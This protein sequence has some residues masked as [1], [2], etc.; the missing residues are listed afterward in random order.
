MRRLMLNSVMN[1]LVLCC[2]GFL[3]VLIVHLSVGTTSVSFRR[4]A[5]PVELPSNSQI[6]EREDIKDLQLTV[7]QLKNGMTCVQSFNQKNLSCSSK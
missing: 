1:D 2:A 3:A 7:I 5:A 4:P 6:K